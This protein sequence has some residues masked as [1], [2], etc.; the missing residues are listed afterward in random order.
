MSKVR[1]G[2]IGVGAFGEVHLAAYKTLH[3][4]EIVAVSDTSESRLREVAAR[5]DVKN[6]YTDYKELC[7]RQDIDLVSIVTP[8]AHH[9]A[10]VMTAVGQGKHI[11][12]EKPIATRAADAAK[13]VEAAEKAGVFLMVGHILRF[14][15]NYGT[16]KR[17]IEE[18]KLGDIVSIHARR[19]R[20]RKLYKIYSREHAIIENSIHDIDLCLWYTQARVE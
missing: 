7:A 5:Y 12:L 1:V 2:V 10:P 6:C 20:P 3:D 11:F 8:E 16:M 18:G 14:E 4:V 9:L 13:I 15:N 19:N 17:K